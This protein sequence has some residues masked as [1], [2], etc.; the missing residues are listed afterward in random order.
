MTSCRTKEG[1]EKGGPGTGKLAGP[2]ILQ[3]LKSCREMSTGQ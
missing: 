2:E 3:V 1:Q